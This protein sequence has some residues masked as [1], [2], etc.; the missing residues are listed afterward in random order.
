MDRLALREK[1]SQNEDLSNSSNNDDDR[2]TNGPVLDPFIQILGKRPALRFTVF[3]ISL[4]IYYALQ[5]MT[6]IQY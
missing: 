2:L 5:R 4:V 3:M 6:C 1:T